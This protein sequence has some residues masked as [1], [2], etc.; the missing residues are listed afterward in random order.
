MEELAG[1]RMVSVTCWESQPPSVLEGEGLESA[2]GRPQAPQAPPRGT[3]PVHPP[4]GWGAA[5]GRCW[6]CRFPSRPPTRV[7]P[8][9][10]H[11]HAHVHTVFKGPAPGGGGRLQQRLEGSGQFP[12]GS[13]PSTCP[14]SVSRERGW[15]PPQ[16]PPAAPHTS[17]LSTI[18]THPEPCPHPP[19]PS[20]THTPEPST[21]VCGAKGMGGSWEVGGS[22]APLTRGRTSEPAP[23]PGLP[24]GH[25]QQ[26]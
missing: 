14:P 16:D 11:A 8:A 1:G 6:A 21:R 26:A 18:L 3:R 17:F 20:Q 4:T 7:L 9:P 23:A 5:L 12:A 15:R 19:P 13:V 22:G 10:P 25:S 24:W 2:V